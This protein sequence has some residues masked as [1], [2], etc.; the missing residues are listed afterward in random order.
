MR[1]FAW[2]MG[3]AL[4]L[5]SFIPYLL[6]E[7]CPLKSPPNGEFILSVALGSDLDGWF[8]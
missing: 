2:I 6:S 7:L 5:S 4:E 1:F 8:I 3:R